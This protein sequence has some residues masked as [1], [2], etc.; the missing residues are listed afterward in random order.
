MMHAEG[1]GE[2]VQCHGDWEELVRRGHSQQ[3]NERSDQ[4]I[5]DATSI[6]DRNL[7]SSLAQ[8][9]LY[10]MV[11]AA[12][13]A[14]CSAGVVAGMRARPHT[15]LASARLLLVRLC[16]GFALAGFAPT[17][18]PQHASRVSHS[19]VWMMCDA[20]EAEEPAPEEEKSVLDSLSAL[21]AELLEKIKGMT[22]ADVASL[23]KDVEKTFNV[24]PKS[25]DD[26][27]EEA[28]E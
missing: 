23:T 3:K 6:S 4:P 5:G 25:G 24:G 27:E 28:A 2:H 18:L 26:D 13:L 11:R 1:R 14:L 22:L 15:P 20:A 21:P 12:A 8:L 19:R 16:V 10:L 17:M 9:R 7:A